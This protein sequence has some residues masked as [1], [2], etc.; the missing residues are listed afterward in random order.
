MIGSIAALTVN[1]A[2]GLPF[3][4]VL[5]QYW[6]RNKPIPYKPQVTNLRSNEDLVKGDFDYLILS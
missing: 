1:T 4:V 6:P 3:I 5:I 2:R